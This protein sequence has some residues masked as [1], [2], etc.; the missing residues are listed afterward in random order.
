MRITTVE[1]SYRLTESAELNNVQVERRMVAEFPTNHSDGRHDV[2]DSAQLG[3]GYSRMI[4]GECREA[5]ERDVDAWLE[6]HGQAPR[7]YQGPRY[8]AWYSYE[9]KAALILSVGVVPPGRGGFYWHTL[10]VESGMRL[11]SLRRLIRDWVRRK[12]DGDR[13]LVCTRPAKADAFLADIARLIEG[14]S[15]EPAAEEVDV[16]VD[17]SSWL[18]DE[19]DEPEEAE[20]AARDEWL[21]GT[22]DG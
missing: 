2:I 5:C 14:A 17:G 12:G 20:D 8:V 21:K 7:Y 9:R 18:A 3:A 19:G 10:S 4:L 1:V 15:A 11:V 16:P 13:W 22:H 6:E